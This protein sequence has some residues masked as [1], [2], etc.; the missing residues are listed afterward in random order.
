MKF[1]VLWCSISS[2]GLKDLGPMSLWENFVSELLELD[3]VNLAQKCP[4][5]YHSSSRLY[6]SHFIIKVDVIFQLEQDAI[7]AVH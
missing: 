2:R 3:I 4:S 1:I 7:N 6:Y 5:T